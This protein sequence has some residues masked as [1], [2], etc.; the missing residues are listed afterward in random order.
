MD[1]GN[2]VVNLCAQGMRA[3]AEGRNADARD[4]FERAWQT[5]ADDYEACVAAHYLARHQPTP[6]QTL[7]WNQECL[8]RADLV[9]DERVSG[10]YASLHINMAKAYGD[11][12][13][14]GK[15]REHFERAAAHVDAVLSRCC[16]SSGSHPAAWTMCNAVTS[17]VRS[18]SVPRS[19]R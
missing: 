8:N 7:H 18:S 6:Q 1:P 12:A 4:L 13:E 11:L 14:P 9:G 5:A 16:S 17:R 3:E 2:P 19:V 15:A 10:F